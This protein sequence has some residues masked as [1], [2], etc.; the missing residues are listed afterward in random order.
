M[1]VVDSTGSKSAGTSSLV[2][3]PWHA[4]AFWAL[5]IGWMIQTA[6]WVNHGDHL[7]RG[8]I[9]IALFFYFVASAV[10]LSMRQGDWGNTPLMRFA[11]TCWSLAWITFVSHVYVAFRY[12]HNWDHDHAVEHTREVSGVG[13][14][15]Y[16]SHTFTLLWTLDVIAWW[17][18][19]AW[20][21]SRSPWID[22]CLH[23]FMAFIIFNGTVVY[24]KGPIVPIGAAMLVVLG[25]LTLRKFFA[26]RA[27]PA[28]SSDIPAGR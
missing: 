10:M 14:G 4:G 18:M 24:E 21:T 12:Y 9:Y 17:G 7:I 19:P 15:I 27:K 5:M 6:P 16:V 25:L 3:L 2:P 23:A 8:T 22:R 26:S 13:W 1:A 20:Y 11:R 28:P